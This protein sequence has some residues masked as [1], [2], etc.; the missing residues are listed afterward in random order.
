MEHNEIGFD[1]QLLDGSKVDV[2]NVT[3][4]VVVRRAGNSSYSDLLD[5][6]PGSGGASSDW[7]DPALEQGRSFREPAASVTLTTI[8]VDSQRAQVEVQFSGAVCTQNN[9]SIQILA[10]VTH[11]GSPGQSLTYSVSLT[12]NDNSNCSSR[13]FN[14][15]ASYPSGWSSQFTSASLNLAPGQSGS[16]SLSVTSPIN[17][18]AAYYD[19]SVNTAQAPTVSAVLTYVVQAMNQ[20]PVAVNDNV[21]ITSKAAVSINALTN[22]S[23]PEGKPLSVVS[24]T[25]GAKGSVQINSDGS[26]TYTPSKGFKSSDQFSYTISDGNSTSSANVSITL[27]GGSTGGGK[28]G[29]KR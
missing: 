11:W 25:Q 20:P 13:S 24:V 26:L 4:G 28:G 15:Q 1:A 9:P 27:S 7:M 19:I 3:N 10:P 22:D 23:D 12:N 18:T 2:A 6:T 14:L 16:T 17:A 29:G 5:M 8:A 21:T